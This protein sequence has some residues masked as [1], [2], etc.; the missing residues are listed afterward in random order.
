[1]T[2]ESIYRIEMRDEQIAAS[3]QMQLVIVMHLFYDIPFVS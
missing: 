2:K 1:M 3:M